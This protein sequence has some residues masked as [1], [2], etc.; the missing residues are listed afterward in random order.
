VAH[1]EWKEITAAFNESDPYWDAEYEALV[2]PLAD[3]RN[4]RTSSNNDRADDFVHLNAIKANWNA[5]ANIEGIY[6]V[7]PGG[8]SGIPIDEE[9]FPDDNFRSYL[10]SQSYG[11]DGMLTG[12][13]AEKV[14]RMSVQ[15]RNIKNMAG[16]EHF[17]AMISFLC[18]QNNIKGADMD[19]LIGRL[20]A[21]SGGLL[22]AIH[23]SNE[24]NVMTTTQVAAAKAKGWVPY[25][26]D[27]TRWQ[28]YEGSIPV[29]RGDVNG[30][31]VVNGTDIQ[32]VINFIVAS[33]YD[34][35]ADVNDDGTV[36]GTDIQEII[37]IIV[38]NL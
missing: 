19:D 8:E 26:H 28:R 30:D 4:K 14:T 12:K 31:G 36:N 10:L 2:I 7:P 37:N 38:N 33:Q 16:I 21:V 22:Y 13:E 9:N 20:P 35:S 6:L 18:Y 29:P 3:I 23:S 1:G 25:Y 27:G 15:N 5:T 34:E 11:Q 32:A 24:G 17:T